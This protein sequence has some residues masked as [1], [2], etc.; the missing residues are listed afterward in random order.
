MVHRPVARA[1]GDGIPGRAVRARLALAAAGRAGD[2]R[3]GRPDDADALRR[4]VADRGAA[5]LR[6]RARAVR[7]PVERDAGTRRLRRIR[8]PARAR[9][10]VVPP[11]PLRPARMALA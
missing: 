4:P 5:A 9:R 10:A 2:A 1:V 6:L 7:R 3:S 8:T 11:L